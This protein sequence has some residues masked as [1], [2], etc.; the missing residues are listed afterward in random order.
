MFKRIK[1][2]T[3]LVLGPIGLAMAGLATAGHAA[4]EPKPHGRARP[5]RLCRFVELEQCRRPP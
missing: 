2:S 4:S 5:W 1:L 3:A